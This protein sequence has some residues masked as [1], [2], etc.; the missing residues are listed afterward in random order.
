MQPGAG[1]Q[2]SSPAD[3]I[4]RVEQAY[5]ALSKETVA[6]LE[7]LYAENVVFKDPANHIEGRDAMLAHFRNAYENVI[8]CRFE[9][10]RSKMVVGSS[11]AYL[12]WV[13]YLR[14][15]KIRHGKTIRVDGAT[16]LE[17]SANQQIIFHQDWF[18]LG[19]MV[20][21]HL[22]LIGKIIR[23]LKLKISAT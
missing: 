14:H 19:A 5:A 9:F 17:F 13:M 8:Q 10:N 4:A 23:F 15:S 20:Y 7:V 22:P 12:N 2:P 18:D 1:E 6:Q 3:A 11:T 21:E 16:L